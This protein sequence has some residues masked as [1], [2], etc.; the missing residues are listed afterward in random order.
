MSAPL[1]SHPDRPRSRS[2]RRVGSGFKLHIS[3]LPVNYQQ[4]SLHDMFS[5]FGNIEDIRIIR[6]GANGLPLKDSV[7]GFVVMSRDEDAKRALEDLN[8]AGWSVSLS[9][10]VMTKQTQDRRINHKVGLLEPPIEKLVMP[11]LQAFQH[12]MQATLIML[13]NNANPSPGKQ[14]DRGL[15]EK[16]I[17]DNHPSAFSL[18]G[19]PALFQNYFLVRE[20]W[21]GN[22]SPATEKKALY[23]AFKVY[24]EIEGIEMFSSK[25]FAF[26]KYRKV[27]SA[28]RAY[29]KAQG[30][31]VDERPV[32]VAFADPTRRIDI[33]GDSNAP[34]DPNF[35]PIDDDNF[36]NLYLGYSTG[37][38][39]PPEPKL[40][41]IF[42]RYGTVKGI[43][44]KQ[45]N[46][47]IRPYAFVDFEKGEQAAY[48]RRHLYIDDKDGLRR[49]EL[50]DRSLEISFKNTN[51][52]VSRSGVKNGVRF[53]ERLNPQDAQ[54]VARRL[55]MKPPE[56][57][58]MIQY[59]AGMIPP[60]PPPGGFPDALI[61][62]PS[63]IPAMFPTHN[64]PNLPSLPNLAPTPVSFPQPNLNIPPPPS[65][66]ISPKTTE[67]DP[68]LGNVVWCGFMT[69]HKTHRVG[70]DATLVKGAAEPLSSIHHL[71]ITHRVQIEDVWKHKAIG[72]ITLEASNETQEKEFNE[73]IAYFVHKQRA[74]FISLKSHIM[75]LLPPT[76][77]ALRL[78]P[79]IVP[80]QL[81]GVFLDPTKPPERPPSPPTKMQ[82]EIPESFKSFPNESGRIPSGAS[83]SDPRLIRRMIHNP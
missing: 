21:I 19:V 76:E 13:L 10:E 69:R 67:E 74:G 35:N 2:P 80:S 27:V 38:V 28:T 22:I 73:Y 77:V 83:M 32:K 47:N 63:Q 65:S 45:A 18:S 5:R 9:K 16:L 34:E 12:N 66:Q 58:N 55:L 48:A 33:L 60:P 14:M 29:E 4:K 40:R 81:L 68:N 61:P 1:L 17:A 50:G 54:E 26:I 82:T 43:H 41:E 30:V 24:G 56:F 37:T 71:N 3:N 39:V 62:N 8:A 70:I 75:L 72:M 44:I 52:I 7:Y 57:L 11:S 36:K 42:S 46:V 6:K 59:P 51:N 49:A 78:Y 64:M 15:L 25:G 53:N 79:K 31:L 23:D 20:V